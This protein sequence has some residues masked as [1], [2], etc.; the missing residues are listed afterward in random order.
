[1]KTKTLLTA[2]ILLI[3]AAC[4]QTEPSRKEFVPIT[5][6]CRTVQAEESK[7]AQNLNENY[8]AAGQTV[9]VQVRNTKIGSWAAYTFTAGEGGV[10]LAP[11]PAPRYPVDGSPVDIV[12]CCPSTA[13][14]TFSIQAD[15]T[16]DAAYKASDLMFAS[17]EQQT[18]Q[19]TPVVL[20]LTH[21]LAKLNLNVTAGTGVSSIGEIRILNVKPTIP[22]NPLTGETGEAGG[23]VINILVSNNGAA[24]IPAQTL[25]GGFLS[26]VTDQGT[27]LYSLEGKTFNPAKQYTLNITV[28]SRAVGAE[29]VIS[30]WNDEGTVNI[31]T[32]D[33]LTF[34]NITSEHIGWLMT[35][36]G[37]IYQTLDDA[38]Q[39]GKTAIAMIC[40]IGEP[41]TADCSAHYRGLAMAL[42]TAAD[43]TTIP[44]C[45][46]VGKGCLT[47]RE[48]TEA[49]NDINGIGNTRTLLDHT[50]RAGHTA[51]AAQAAVNNND[52]DYP[53]GTSGW[54]LPS[55]GQWSKA[56]AA[57]MGG[58]GLSGNTFENYRA[59]NLNRERIGKAGL[60]EHANATSMSGA[61]PNGLQSD[62]YWSS[63][64][65][66]TDITLGAWCYHGGDGLAVTSTESENRYV[67]AFLAF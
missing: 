15:Q 36:D 57:L 49:L 31:T 12:A 18:E 62:Y 64:E 47:P 5:L 48:M 30:G 34:R 28:N 24:I 52:T 55:L 67:R 13:G 29:N 10:M 35:E 11:D 25:T 37:F 40:Y 59:I 19:T 61:L 51:Q 41:G 33:P 27:A 39:A 17:V 8:L 3:L 58:T 9:K 23:T 1:M 38:T 6:T 60:N 53:E 16:T 21:K 63:T 7:A 66:K 50:W 14:T 26:I 54:F 32:K 46:T 65:S 2:L 42:R 44:L 43:N 4:S 56:L 45:E 20:S 22:F